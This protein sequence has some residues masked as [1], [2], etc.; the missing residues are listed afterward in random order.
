MD[1]NSQTTADGVVESSFLLGDVPGVLWSPVSAAA[2]APVILMGHG[3]GLSKRAPGLVARARG[4]VAGHGFHAVAIDAPGHGERPRPGSDQE[5]V[6]RIGAARR[7]GGPI[8][9]FVDRLNESL[10]ERTVPEWQAVM[11]ALQTVPGLEA[12][13]FG[14][15]GMTLATAIGVPL[16]AADARIRAAVFGGFYDFGWVTEAASRVTIPIEFILSW[17]DPELDRPSGLALFD[18]FGSRDKVLR[19]H[20]GD[21]RH[22]PASLAEDS[23]RFLARVLT[24]VGG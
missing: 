4:L 10:A 2:G 14:Y 3:G 19:A 1:F 8:V 21:H 6:A 11:D 15:T 23:N 22:V 24:G 5:L 20:T 9:P 16:A 17:D 13:A 18:A 7:A 12:S